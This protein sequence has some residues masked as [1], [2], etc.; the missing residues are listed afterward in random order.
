MTPSG[1]RVLL[2]SLAALLFLATLLSAGVSPAAGNAPT[3]PGLSR[4]ETL[5][6]GERIYRDGILPSGEPLTAV[7]QGDIPVEGTMFSCVSCHLRSGLGSFE[8]E[9]LTPPTNGDILYQPWD[10]HRETAKLRKG[11]MEGTMKLRKRTLFY[12]TRVGEF[13]SR[14]AYT[15]ETLADAIR[16]GA[17]PEGRDFIGVMPRYPFGDRDMAILIEYLKSLSKD[18]SPGVTETTVRFATVV[19]EEVSQKERDELLVP[20]ERYI[21]IYNGHLRRQTRKPTGARAEEG[22][23]RIPA[24]PGRRQVSLAVWELKGPAGNVAGT[25][26]GVLSQGTGLRA[27]RGDHDEGVA[28]DPRVQRGERDPLPPPDHRSSRRLGDRLV[29]A[30]LLEGVL[31]GGGDGRASPGENGGPGPGRNRRPGLP[32]YAGRESLRRRIP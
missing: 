29:H 3:V 4:E 32:R 21:K 17:D 26:R 20:L 10:S 1:T 16:E 14:P 2:A 27:A 23:W 28:A 11:T 30:L 7:V 31:P 6:L 19:T 13:P 15:D 8:G 5:R 22:V 18:P 12:L 9:V 25:A 24:D